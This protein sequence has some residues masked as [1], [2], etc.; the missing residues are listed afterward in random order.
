MISYLRPGDQDPLSS[1]T[2]FS[3]GFAQGRPVIDL[4]YQ[5]RDQ[6]SFFQR[7]LGSFPDSCDLKSRQLPDIG[8]GLHHLIKKDFDSCRTGKCSPVIG[9]QF[10]KSLIQ[11]RLIF[12]RFRPYSRQFQDFCSQGSQFC[13]HCGNQIFWPGHQDLTA[14]Q[15]KF[16]IPGKL[17]SQSADPAYNN[18][19][20]SF[21]S[22]SFYFLRK[23]FYCGNDPFLSCG[24]SL[25]EHRGRHIRIHSCRQKGRA[26]IR[27]G[28]DTHK[29]YQRSLGIYQGF[30]INI[31]SLSLPFMTGDDMQGRGIVPMGHRDPVIGRHCD[32]RSHSRHYLI[33]DTFFCQKLQ[34]LAASSEKKR[35]SSLQADYPI[36]FL[37]FLHQDL[38]DL[39][40]GHC[41]MGSP[42]SHVNSLCFFWDLGQYSLAH[43]A[44][45]DHNFCAAQD[46]LSFYCKKSRIPRAGS[47]QPDLAFTHIYLLLYC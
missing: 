21:H 5:I 11:I 30:K 46:F 7:P 37:S 18:N 17:I 26:D 28:R 33:G 41:M 44:V 12:Q 6:S 13:G 14:C 15:R 36:A 39:F 45:I 38:I 20:R 23:L 32:R 16:F 22:L 27:K 4:R 2:G 1:L 47:Y 9:V 10:L 8:P 42:F 24:G 19:S 34:F 25:L 31:I 43:Q 40:L 3:Q 35:I 29:E